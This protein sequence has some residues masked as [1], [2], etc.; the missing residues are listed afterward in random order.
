MTKV[1]ALFDGF[2]HYRT[3]VIEGGY[4]AAMTQAFLQSGRSHKRKFTL[5]CFSALSADSTSGSYFGKLCA[6][7]AMTGVP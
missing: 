7:G 6:R 1:T 4:E 3:Y 2:E 5:G